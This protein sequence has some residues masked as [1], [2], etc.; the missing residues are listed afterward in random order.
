MTLDSLRPAAAP[1]SNDEACDVVAA[2]KAALAEHGITLPSLGVD[3]GTWTSPHTPT[4]IELGRCNVATARAIVAALT[5][6]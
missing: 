3:H 2:L 1:A 5:R 6:S 4:L